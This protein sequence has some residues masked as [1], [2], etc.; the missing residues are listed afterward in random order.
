MPDYEKLGFAPARVL[1]EW[2]CHRR[3]NRHLAEH[4]YGLGEALRERSKR[5]A[6]LLAAGKTTP[7]A[8]DPQINHEISSLN[9]PI[10]IVPKKRA[11]D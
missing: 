11:G 8:E 10:P 2:I 6:P 5:L 7:L 1:T 3:A 9:L 4:I